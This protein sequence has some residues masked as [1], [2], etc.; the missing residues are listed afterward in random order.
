MTSKTNPTIVQWVLSLVLYA[1]IGAWLA[2]IYLATIGELY[3]S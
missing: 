3:V 2:L 1:G